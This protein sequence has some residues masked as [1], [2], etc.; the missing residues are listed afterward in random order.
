MRAQTTV[1]FALGTV[2]FLLAAGTVLAAIPSLVDPAVGR[3]PASVVVADRAADRLAHDVLAAP[4]RP[5]V[6][7]E[8]ATESFF[9]GSPA[10]ARDRLAVADAVGLNVTLTTGTGRR[11]LGPAP[12]EGTNSV[13]RGRRAVT[14]DGNHQLLRVSVW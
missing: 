12:P 3:D 14:L 2:V 13:Y 6:L 9:E 11:S 7:N 8:S 4:E 1:D 5:Y 10:T